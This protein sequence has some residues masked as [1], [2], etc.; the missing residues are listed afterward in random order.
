M[1]NFHVTNQRQMK[2][3]MQRLYSS[4]NPL[5][6]IKEYNKKQS[7]GGQTGSLSFKSNASTRE[8]QNEEIERI[9]KIMN[10]PIENLVTNINDYQQRPFSSNFGGRRPMSK[11]FLSNRTGNVKNSN[12]RQATVR[13]LPPHQAQRKERAMTAN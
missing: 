11:H 4:G 5:K 6:M 8:Y 13:A 1:Q 12:L 10:E 7:M 9:N 2:P 3:A